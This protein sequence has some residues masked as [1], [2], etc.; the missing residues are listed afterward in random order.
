MKNMSE[1]RLAAGYMTQS[2]LA[3]KLGVK[4]NQVTRWENGTRKPPLHKLPILAEILHT[5]EG[6]IIAAVTATSK[7]GAV[8]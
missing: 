4:R 6:E 7:S 1:Y 8:V 5:T 3:E 2:A